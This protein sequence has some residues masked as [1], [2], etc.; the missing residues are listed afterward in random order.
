MERKMEKIV[1]RMNLRQQ[2][3][4][5]AGICSLMLMAEA[6]LN[7]NTP[8]FV[9]TAIF[10]G[11]MSVIMFVLAYIFGNV[12][13]KRATTMVEGL[14]AMAQGDLTQK[15]R[16]SGKD[17]YAWMCWEYSQARKGFSGLIDEVLNS[18]EQLAKEAENLAGI[19]QQSSSGAQR[20]Q[21]EIEKVA[22][23]MNQMSSTVNAVASNAGSAANAAQEADT[24]AQQGCE[25][26]NQSLDTINSLAKEVKN[27]SDVIEKLKGDSI[28]IGTVL[29][30]IRDIAEQTNLL[31]LNA[32]IEAARAGEQGRGFAVVADEVRTLASRTQQ[33]TQEINEMIE[34]LQ[35]GANQAVMVMEKGRDKAEMSVE[36][37]AQAGEALKSITNVVNSIKSMNTEIASA[38]EDQS[39]TADEINQNIVNISEVSHETS[40]GAR[41]TSTASDELAKLAVGLQEKLGKFKVA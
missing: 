10:A 33:S 1:T 2:F 3:Y 40:E 7:Y 34:R 29:D 35:N 28:S 6:A 36:Q 8:H 18:V 5:F 27:T 16:M 23:A 12:N 15:M 24:E 37:A 9:N 11:V 26:V 4:C 13:A 21:S 14:N 31:A 39:M 38:A 30:V 25:V 41:K 20:Q 19:T 22:S 17:E 32:A